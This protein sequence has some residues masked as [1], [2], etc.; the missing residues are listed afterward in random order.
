MKIVDLEYTP[1]F[2]PIE[3]PLRYSQGAHPGFSRIIVQLKTDEGLVGLGECYGGQGARRSTGRI[4][5]LA[6]RRGPISTGAHPLETRLARGPQ[7]IR[8]RP[9]LCRGGIRLPRFTGQSAGKAGVGPL[10]GRV[11]DR[12]PF[13]AYLFYRYNNP[14]GWGEVSNA[15]QMVAWAKE[16][17][18]KY[19]FQTIKFKN[20]VFPVDEEIE[21]FIALRKAFPRHKI[22]MD[23]N[24]VW[25]VSTAI[26]VA[27]AV[28]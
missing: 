4:P 25:S 27:K 17:V 18:Q 1:V 12:I 8:P 20:G 10:G 28:A 6:P 23:P 11:R 24:A 26:R 15:E 21:T 7:A 14:Q 19:N 2:V 16:L 3:A 5:R 13:C 22:R 9:A